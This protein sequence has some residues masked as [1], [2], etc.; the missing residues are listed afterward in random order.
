MKR[1]LIL[2]AI[3]LITLAPLAQ[4]KGQDYITMKRD[5]KVYWIRGGETIRMMISVPLKDGSTVDYKGTIKSKNG[6]VKQ[7]QKK[8]KFLMDGTLIPHKK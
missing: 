8:D 3:S 1:L 7:L 5:G 2:I 6:Q 4:Q